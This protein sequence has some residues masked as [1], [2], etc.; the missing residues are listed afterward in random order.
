MP[1]LLDL[2][3]TDFASDGSTPQE[4]R[5]HLTEHPLLSVEAVARLAD[6]LPTNQ[7]E[8]N[9]AQGIGNVTPGGATPVLEQS[10]GDVARGIETNGC[11]MVLKNI[12]RD[13]DYAKL[14]DEA[15]NE[16]ALMLPGGPDAMLRRQGYL[17]L[18]AP[19]S[20]TPTHID[21]EHNFLLQIRG[22]KTMN[23]GTFADARSE[24]LELERSFGVGHRNMDY[25]PAAMTP[26]V[27]DPGDGVYV[28]VAA[29]HWVQNGDTVS[30]SLSITWRTEVALRAERVHAF[31]DRLRRRGLEPKAPG[32]NPKVDRAKAQ[33]TRVLLKAEQASGE[34]RARR[35]Q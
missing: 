31:N 21:P 13:P 25:V 29:P 11:W 17:F 6:R 9:V 20:I 15:L 24:Q 7:V 32:G 22:R 16:V 3:Q 5:H 26:F 4:V 33:V 23:I 27:M 1:E 18:S 14:V 12:E 2:Q 35:G 19:G 30:V 28:P 10:P 34:L 8:H